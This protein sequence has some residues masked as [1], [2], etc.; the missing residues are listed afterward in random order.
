MVKSTRAPHRLESV[1]DRQTMFY[2]DKKGAAAVARYNSSTPNEEENFGDDREIA[3]SSGSHRDKDHRA[4]ELSASISRI[5]SDDS[6]SCSFT[7]DASRQESGIYMKMELISSQD[8]L[9]IDLIERDVIS[10]TVSTVLFI[11]IK[12]CKTFKA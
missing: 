2:S 8:D 12:C 1:K 5:K 7:Q 9:D 10:E 6:D 4:S 11:S 3:L